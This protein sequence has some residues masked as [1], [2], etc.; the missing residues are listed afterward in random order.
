MAGISS[1]ASSFESPSNKFKYNGKE[2]QR[3]EFSDGSGLEWLDYGARMYDAQ[4]GRFFTQD[5]FADYYYSLSPYQYT[6]G[7][8]VN[9]IDENGDYIT[10]DKKDKDGNVMLSLLYENGE[11]FFYSKDKEGNIVKGDAWDGTDEFITNAVKDLNDVASTKHGKTIVGDLQSSKYGYSI[12]EAGNIKGT[13]FSGDDNAKGGGNIYY[14]QKGG[15]HP[16][17][18]VNRSAV[19]LGHE[20]YHGWGF[21]YTNQTRGMNFGQRLQRETSAVHFENYLRASFGESVMRTHY[22]LQ[23]SREKVASSSIQEAK[24]YNLPA[25]NYLKI[26][27][28][29]TNDRKFQRD[30]DNTYVKPPFSPLKVIDTRTQKW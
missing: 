25:A 19:I 21:E 29:F 24:N 30:V 12:S 4:I 10:V 14:L 18:N 8:P 26:V 1:K 15:S 6:A 3:Q 11:A 20:L 17:A 5:R 7:S 28:V 22:T 9:F 23:G 2:E 16:D 13:G 27:P